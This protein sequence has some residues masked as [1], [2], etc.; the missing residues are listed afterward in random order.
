[1][2]G[3]KKTDILFVGRKGIGKSHLITALTNDIDKTKAADEHSWRLHEV[4]ASPTVENVSELQGALN[5]KTI[6]LIAMC[7]EMKD[8][9]NE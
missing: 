5:G 7:I 6:Q 1:M 3:R 2:A 4:D 9:T 8:I